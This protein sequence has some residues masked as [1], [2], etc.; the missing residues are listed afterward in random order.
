MLNPAAHEP[1]TVA[2]ENVSATIGSHKSDTVGSGNTG[3]AGH[4]IGEIGVGHVIVGGVLSW[5]T[6]VRL[7]VAVLP[8]SSVAV[9]V[10]VTL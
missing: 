9:H 10:L 1:A 7:Q 5:T 6:T 4:C 8:Q 2:S 3:V